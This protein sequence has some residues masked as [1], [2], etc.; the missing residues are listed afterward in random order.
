MLRSKTLWFLQRVIDQR[1]DLG[2]DPSAL[3]R[4]LH[5]AD[6]EH[7]IPGIDEEEGAGDAIPAI[8][9]DRQSGTRR[10]HGAYGKAEAEPAVGAGKIEIVA[11]DMRFRSDMIRRHQRDGLRLE[12]A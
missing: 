1:L 7:I 6:H 8:F 2:L 10:L 12:I 4:G 5:H 9:A 11:R 3:R